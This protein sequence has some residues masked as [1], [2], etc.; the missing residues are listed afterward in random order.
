MPTLNLPPPV[1]EQAPLPG[2]AVPEIRTEQA[3]GP[4]AAPERAPSSAAA[5]AAAA[6]PVMPL[7]PIRDNQAIPA[8]SG[9]T[10]TT[11]PAA[12]GLIKDDDLIEKEW[13]E[14]AKRIVEHTRDDPHQQSEQ[15]TLVKADYMKKRYNKTVKVS[16]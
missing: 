9:V 8:A 12:G 11:Q 4:A 5:G 14:K 10:P 3:R 6:Q 2:A 1:G 7:P 15:L 13:V 16:K